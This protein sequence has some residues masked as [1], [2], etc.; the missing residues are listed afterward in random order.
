MTMEE[1]FFEVGLQLLY[2]HGHGRLGREQGGIPGT[3]L[4]NWHTRPGDVKIPVA[5]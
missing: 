5:A 3:D 1:V 4:K 2:L